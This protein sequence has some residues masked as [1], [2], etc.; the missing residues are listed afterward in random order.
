ML[1]GFQIFLCRELSKTEIGLSCVPTNAQVF[2][3]F[4]EK[5]SKNFTQVTKQKA[6]AK[7]LLRLNGFGKKLSNLRLRLELHTCSTKMLLT[8]SLTSRT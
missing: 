8:E 1:S 3:K 6:E 5:L 7:K 2:L 4:G